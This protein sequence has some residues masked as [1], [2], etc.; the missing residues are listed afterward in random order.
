MSPVCPDCGAVLPAAAPACPRCALTLTGPV[1]AELWQVDTELSRLRARQEVLGRRRVELIGLLRQQQPLRM[2]EPVRTV[3]PPAPRPE[4]SR[5]TAQN[6]LLILGGLLMAVAAIVFTVV[7]WGFLGLAG[8]SAI[9]AALTA[10][11]LAV[12]LL[13]LKRGLNATAETIGVLGV[14]LLLLDG[15]AARRVGLLPGM[16]GDDYAALLIGLVALAA[17][18]YARVARLKAPLPIAIVLAQIPLPLAAISPSQELLS[19]AFAVTAAVDVVIWFFAGGRERAWKGAV[20]IV[21]AICLGLSWTVAWLGALQ[22]LGSAT[23]ADALPYALA[24]MLLAAVALFAAHATKAGQVAI[25]LAAAAGVLAMGVLPRTAL[26][27]GWQV[28]PFEVAA[29]A[30]VLAAIRLRPGLR[31]AGMISGAVLAGIAVLPL[32]EPVMKALF[33]PA[34]HVVTG[35]WS[36][37]PAARPAVVAFLLLAVASWALTRR[38]PEA[39]WGVAG[40]GLTAGLLAAPA[41][42]PSL[43]I[44]L[45]QGFV[46]S[47]VFL[48]GVPLALAVVCTMLAR[49]RPEFAFAAGV[50]AVEAVM[51]AQAREWFT[52]AC[53]ALLLA[54]WAPLYRR[55]PALVGA[56]LAGGGLAWA[57]VGHA[58]M[59]MVESCAAGLAVASLL[60]L[61]G[62]YGGSR[63]TR[64]SPAQIL[65]GVSA[66]V[67]V[68]VVVEA[69]TSP[70]QY[71]IFPWS[72]W[73]A[74][75]TTRPLVLGAL[76]LAGAVA[77]AAM[78]V[79]GAPGAWMQAAGVVAGAIV[80]A[81]IPVTLALP[82]WAQLVVLVAG[83]FA[84]GAAAMRP[85]PRPAGAGVVLAAAA[86]GLGS[87]AVLTSLAERDAT[88]AVLPLLAVL[89]AVAA[90]VGRAKQLSVTLAAGL[91]AAEVFAVAE[92][93]GLRTASLVGAGVGVVTIAAGFAVRNRAIGYL[94][95]AFLLSASWMRLWADGVDVVEAYTLPFSV[96]LLGIG[97][98]HAREVSS[99]RAYGAGLLFTFLPSLLAEPTP[100]RSLMLGAAALAV[101]VSGA[102]MRLQAPV[103]LGSLTL[104]VVAVRELS[105]WLAELMVV[106]PKWIPIAVGGLL[107]IVVGATYEARKRDVVRLRT[108]VAGLR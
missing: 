58:G 108:A 60:A 51:W 96:V 20:E 83:T 17:A 59:L 106:V 50:C 77:V 48:V 16:A 76:L 93:A 66:L 71:V 32:A 75:V 49:T 54:L 97:W 55:T 95:T 27:G 104:G 99:W 15:Y 61:L 40:A 86:I 68:D 57:L 26:P 107:L 14:A 8:R 4:V 105:P 28:L 24:Y 78:K 10:I 84:A 100:I 38:R 43:P 29:L 69:V 80:V 30:V 1:A 35:G 11:T 42:A 63:K 31:R 46:L 101:V 21:T 53:L 6:T 82:Y 22:S 2:P 5:R 102:R 70:L 34:S 88:L 56:A 44:G 37:V 36:T 65:A 85:G 91:A 25:P 94:G 90:Y 64:V 79:R 41:F 12:P 52:Y 19:G 47:L 7:S 67:A 3:P 81:A 87:I 73:N 62:E 74:A 98:W 18:G 45:P 13:L 103:V 33:V 89:A 39:W 72:G 23:V 9:M 92:A